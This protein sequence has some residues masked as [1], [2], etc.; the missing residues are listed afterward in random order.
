MSD[1]TPAD[2][3]V[4][5][6]EPEAEV[7]VLDCC[8]ASARAFLARSA[9]AVSAAAEVRFWL[10]SALED[11]VEVAGWAAEGA[12]TV[13]ALMSRAALRNQEA[14]WSETMQKTKLRIKD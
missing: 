5:V 8:A 11:T 1:C 7:A 13:A 3:P 14:K 10:A 4:A 2:P 12:P 9:L 6:A